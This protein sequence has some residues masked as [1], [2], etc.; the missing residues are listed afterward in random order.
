MVW[1]RTRPAVGRRSLTVGG[2]RSFVGGGRIGV[3]GRSR[4]IGGG[5]TSG[6]D[7]RATEREKERVKMKCETRLMFV[8]SFHAIRASFPV[9]VKQHFSWRLHPRLLQSH[10]TFGK[11]SSS[12][13]DPQPISN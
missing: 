7:G 1:G 9:T 2:R 3:C 12:F 8:K 6:G 10:Q 13:L 11:N 5:R 4:F